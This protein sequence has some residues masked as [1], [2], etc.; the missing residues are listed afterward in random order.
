MVV[1]LLSR[2]D[3]GDFLADGVVV[4]GPRAGCGRERDCEQ[5]TAESHCANGSVDSAMCLHEV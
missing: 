2:L 4:E 1:V 3:R 5:S